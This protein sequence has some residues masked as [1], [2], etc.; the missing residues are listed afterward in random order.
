MKHFALKRHCLKMQRG[1]NHFILFRDQDGFWCAAPPG[2]VDLVEHP[3]GWGRTA[4]DAI[5]DLLRQPEFHNRASRGE[6][7]LPR[8]VDFA[9]VSEPDG[10]KFRVGDELEKKLRHIVFG[11]DALAQQR[12]ANFRVISNDTAAP[13]FKTD[14]QSSKGS[15]S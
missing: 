5:I 3:T 13:R 4:E 2:F 6:W 1:P 10:A 9:E 12:R 7:L 11:S 15:R 8:A 14:F